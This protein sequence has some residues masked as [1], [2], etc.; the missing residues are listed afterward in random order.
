LRNFPRERI[1]LDVV[2]RSS[3]APVS[4]PKLVAPELCKQE[5]SVEE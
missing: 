3:S 5:K 4:T 2:V 1:I